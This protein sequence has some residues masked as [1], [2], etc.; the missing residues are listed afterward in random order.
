MAGVPYTFATATT[1]IPLSQLDA[2]FNTTLTLGNTSV[3]LGNTVT[4]IGNL[5]LTNVTISS[6]SGIAA[7]TVAY[8]NSSGVLSSSTNLSYNGTGL[9][10]GVS[11]ATQLLQLHNGNLYF[12]TA[13][14]VMWDAGASWSITSDA[15]TKLAFAAGG[16]ERMRIASNGH[17]SINTTTDS[18][19]LTVSATGTTQQAGTFASAG[20]SYFNLALSCGLGNVNM[21]LASASTTD[22][23]LRFIN[24]GGS[25]VLRIQKTGGITFNN[26]S[27]LTNSTLN[28]YETGTWTPVMNPGS[29]TTYT[30]QTGRYTKIGNMVY[31]YFAITINAINTANTTKLYGLPFTSYNAGTVQTSPICYWVSAATAFTYLVGYVEN[32]STDLSFAAGTTASQTISTNG[33]AVFGSGTTLIGTAIYQATF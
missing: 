15:S 2:N 18:G 28:D 29:T 31:A 5:T 16:S 19:Q 3:G 13:N 21:Y 20:A 27:A 1:S 10:L 23:S 17:V 33:P 4:T 9:G 22:E 14:Y 25:E 8:A 11:A 6:A 24:S 32:N 26:S 30:S 12:D 7:N